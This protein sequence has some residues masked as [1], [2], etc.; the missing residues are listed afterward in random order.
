MGQGAPKQDGGDNAYA[1]IWIMAMILVFGGAI[2]FFFKAQII[3]AIFF[4][5]VWEGKLVYLLLSTFQSLTFNIIPL[6]RLEILRDGIDYMQM[7]D[8]GSV[9]GKKL[10][11][12]MNIVG[13]WLRWPVGGG[14]LFMAWHLHNSN[15]TAKYKQAYNMKSLLNEEYRNWPQVAPVVGLDLVKEDIDEGPWAMSMTPLAISEKNNLLHKELIQVIEPSGRKGPIEMRVKVDKAAARRVFI[16][17]LGPYWHGVKS[18]SPQAKFIFAACLCRIERDG[19][20]GKKL[21]DQAALSFDSS[22]NTVDLSGADAII[23]KHQGSKVVQKIVNKHA[24]VMTVM[25]SMLEAARLDGVFPTSDFLW[26]KPYDRKL[27]YV[28]NCVGRQT[29]YPEVAG[30]Y[31]HWYAE[32]ELRRRCMVPI[33]DEAVR[34]LEIAIADIKFTPPD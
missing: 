20:T 11:A 22:K 26:L 8:P 19:A 2:W 13:W 30:I 12:G 7:V 33:V 32:R 5:K 9:S 27:W 3:T 10:W 16:S 4:I 34:G 24:Y 23:K 1:P 25:C 14:L 31:A 15:F 17:Q 29:P 21:L 6:R 28:L 18:L